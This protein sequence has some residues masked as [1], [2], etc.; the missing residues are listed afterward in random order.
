MLT[1]IIIYYGTAYIID[2]LLRIRKG[3]HPD[4][5][6]WI[7]PHR[8]TSAGVKESVTNQSILTNH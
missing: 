2:L 7:V 6:T 5:D 3:I 4:L 8:Q 1:T